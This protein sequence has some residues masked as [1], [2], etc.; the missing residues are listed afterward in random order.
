MLS[1]GENG[2]T[3]ATVVLLEEL[4]TGPDELELAAH[5]A[6]GESKLKPTSW[7]AMW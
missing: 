2:T 3:G 1:T 7:R 5:V 4:L 6:V